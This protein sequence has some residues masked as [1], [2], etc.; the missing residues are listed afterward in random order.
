MSK[1][2]IHESQTNSTLLF[3]TIVYVAFCSK[4]TIFMTYSHNMISS[5]F[6]DLFKGLIYYINRALT[7]EF[8]VTFK[9]F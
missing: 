9:D 8:T 3:Y 1:N 7:K 6:E 5:T 4:R 2:A